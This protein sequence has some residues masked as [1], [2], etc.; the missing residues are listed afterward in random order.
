MPEGHTIHRLARDQT[1]DLVGVPVRTAT[2]QDRFAD[3]AARLDRRTIER[4]EAYGKHLF[5]WWDGGE[6]LHV[7]LG[8]FGKW[9]R[10]S[11]PP[12]APTGEMRLRLEGPTHTWDLAGAITC[13][14]VGPDDRDQVVA[15]LG[16]D[17]LRRDAKPEKMWDRLHR[18]RQP[19]GALL[20]DQAV[21]AGIG[22]V[23][24]SELLFLVGVHPRRA[25]RDV[26]RDEFD[27]LWLETVQQLRLG[28]R[29]NR[30]VT[31][32]PHELTRSGVKAKAKDALYVYKREHCRWCDSPLDV[33]T[34]AGR[35]AWACPVHQT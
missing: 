17:P 14:L 15:G 16:P 20:M 35:R 23:Y 12:P 24:R 5:Q 28:V 25:G 7:H 34:L 21:V 33:V 10:R 11:S 18:S 13:R 8:L 1:A 19:I 22:N 29:R 32:R 3:G 9:T 6:V 2:V 27:R 31:R 4:V 30:I 26:T